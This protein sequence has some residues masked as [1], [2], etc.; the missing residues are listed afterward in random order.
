MATK[1]KTVF[2]VLSK[3]DVTRN[4]KTKEN[5]KYLP[6]AFVWSEIRSRYPDARY[7]VHENENGLPYF[8]SELGLIVKTT[9]VISGDEL[10][11][12]LPVMDH[13]NKAMKKN[14]Y[15]YEIFDKRTN[16]KQKKYVSAATMADINKTIMRCLVKNIAMFGLG[17][18][19]YMGEDTADDLDGSLS[20]FRQEKQDKQAR[21]RILVLAGK[22]FDK[23]SDRFNE[24]L[25]SV[26]VEKKTT[27]MDSD[28][29]A[30]VEA[31]LKLL[32][33]KGDEK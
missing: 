26:G 28:E 3:I 7:A 1:D 17:M 31:R 21:S 10:D 16:T 2:S 5:L 18:C 12:W 6:W 15:S 4:V 11:M 29:L 14:E 25:K 13:K 24:W 8:E 30:I 20:V 27:E 9:V 22:L 32:E 33:K 23:S 19:L